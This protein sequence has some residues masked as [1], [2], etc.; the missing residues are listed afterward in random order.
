MKLHLKKWLVAG[1]VALLVLGTGATA[2]SAWGP[3]TA[4]GP[5]GARGPMGGQLPFRGGG[6]EAI[7]QKLGMTVEALQTAL[8]DGK[9]IADL[10]EEK[11]VALKDLK[12]ASDAAQQEAMRTGIE[13]AVT[14]GK[15]TR[16]QADWMLEGL[17]KGY[18]ARGGWFGR[19]GFGAGQGQPGL[20]AAAQALKLSVH[21]MSLQ[22][23]AGRSLADLAEKQGV[24]IEDVQAA[25]EAARKDAIR[26]QIAAAVTAGKL[27][28][29]QADW[30]LKGIEQGYGP[31]RGMPG[32]WGRPGMHGGRGMDCPLGRPGTRPEAPQGQKQGS[33]AGFHG[34]NRFSANPA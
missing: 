23:W 2:V 15:L 25:I 31:G 26:T 18:G 34:G 19:G 6:Q 4:W 27:T 9:T 13:Q 33:G 14:A 5:G 7:A 17:T 3:G 1:L 21:E 30:I 32:M 24:K 22:M 11:G 29:E 8:K 12:A 10:A 16:A 20:E 28:Q